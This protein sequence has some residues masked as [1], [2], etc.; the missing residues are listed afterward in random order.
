[1]TIQGNNL[2]PTLGSKIILI[3]VIDTMM[4]IISTKDVERVVY[5]GCGVKGALAWWL[6][7]CEEVGSDFGPSFFLGCGCG[8]GC[9]G[10]LMV[11]VGP[12]RCGV[13]I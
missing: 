5:D 12:L 4:S 3:K 1:M 8:G 11:L 13:V 2:P 6:R 9:G 10:G 7:G